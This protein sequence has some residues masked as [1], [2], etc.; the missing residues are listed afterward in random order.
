M[1]ASEPRWRVFL[2]PG[3]IALAAGVVLF[4]VLCF[5]VF[6]PWQLGKNGRTAE[7]NDRV[8]RAL[9]APPAPLAELLR[10]GVGPQSEWR[11]VVVVGVYESDKQVLLRHRPV[12]GTAQGPQ[13]L[14]PLRF[15]DGRTVLVD[16]G[17]LPQGATAAPPAPTGD[18]ALK[19]RLRLLERTPAGRPAIMTIDGSQQLEAID[20]SAIAPLVGAP[21]EPAYLQLDPGQPGALG[22]LAEPDLDPGPYL[23]YGLQWLAF[24]VI[25]LAALGYFGY[26]ELR[27]TEGHEAEEP[28]RATAPRPAPPP[29]RAERKRQLRA[30]LA[31][32]AYEPAAAPSLADRYGR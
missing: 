13:V 25:A 6:A 8:S 2:R 32:K 27:P 28:D 3:W 30:A 26:S 12:H 19:A 16:R 24:G 18:V 10:T 15:D 4:A 5:W 1:T 29:N 23:S 11:A 17:Y 7:R 31:G 21:L 14:T 20:A 9:E 22:A